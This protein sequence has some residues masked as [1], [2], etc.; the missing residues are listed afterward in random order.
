VTATNPPPLWTPISATTCSLA[1]RG[2]QVSHCAASL[3]SVAVGC[4]QFRS[5]R[6]H[7]NSQ[8]AP[9][10]QQRGMICDFGA[11]EGF[12]VS[13]VIVHVLFVHERDEAIMDL[14]HHCH[15]WFED[16][17][18]A[19]AIGVHVETLALDGLDIQQHVE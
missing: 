3:G 9:A 19:W 15:S 10:T 11:L 4:C 6:C 13:T 8:L 17:S 16:S 7:P 2:R 14:W 5:L 1:R 12:V 18:V